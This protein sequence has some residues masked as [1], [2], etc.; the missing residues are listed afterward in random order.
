MKENS[1]VMKQMGRVMSIGCNRVDH[2]GTPVAVPSWSQW[3]QAGPHD[4][5]PAKMAVLS[6]PCRRLWIETALNRLQG[7][8][9]MG[10]GCLPKMVLIS[11]PVRR[12]VKWCLDHWRVPCGLFFGA[13][14]EQVFV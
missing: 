7:R 11:H 13:E 6:P 12:V 4:T 5:L 14:H 10:R 9:G 2:L 3:R 1:Q 8:A